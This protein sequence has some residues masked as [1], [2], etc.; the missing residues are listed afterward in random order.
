MS[1]HISRPRRG[2]SAAGISTARMQTPRAVCAALERRIAQADVMREEIDERAHA[3]RK[4]P[5]TSGIDGVNV[6]AIA[7]IMAL[8]HRHE[9]PGLDVRTDVKDGKPRQPGPSQRQQAD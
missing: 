3:R 5:A 6:F 7:R 2:L 4:R 1:T 8:K 9:A